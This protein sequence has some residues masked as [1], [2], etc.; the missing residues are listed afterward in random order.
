MSAMAGIR[1]SG[2]GIR[3]VIVVAMAVAGCGGNSTTTATSPSTPTKPSNEIWSSVLAPGGTSSR[4]FTVNA[5]G[6]VSV[7]MTSAGATVGL[8][9]GLPRV[10]GGGCRLGVSVNASAS[11]APQITTQ[12]DAGQYCVQ[13]FDLGTLTDPIPFAITIDH[14]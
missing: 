8:G 13:V 14:P 6:T 9:V 3:W 2:F 5:A 11:S 4:S 7:T 12:A 1:D 10:T